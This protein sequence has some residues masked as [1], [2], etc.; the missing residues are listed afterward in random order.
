M[1]RKE[2]K[3]IEIFV[4]GKLKCIIPDNLSV[5]LIIE[6]LRDLYRGQEVVAKPLVTPVI[7]E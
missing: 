6:N 7:V 1:K 4:A 3:E 5:P 2:V